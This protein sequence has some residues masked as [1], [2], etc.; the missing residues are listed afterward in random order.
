M[1]W[2]KYLLL[3]DFGQQLDLED[4]KEE[5]RSLRK[6]ISLNNA[7]NSSV[8]QRLERLEKENDELKLYLS[9][10]VV[11]LKNTGAITKDQLENVVEM[12]DG[13]DGKI[14]GKHKGGINT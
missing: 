7:T 13:Y 2:G 4:Q 11:L 1:G 3:G 9:S 10:L 14:D 6:R 12:V 5:I 8:T